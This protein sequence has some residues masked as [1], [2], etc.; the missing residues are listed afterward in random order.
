ML[1]HVGDRTYRDGVDLQA[2]DFYEM[3]RQHVGRTSTSAPTPGDFL[4]AFEEAAKVATSILC[5]TVSK[6]FQLKPGVC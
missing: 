6:E 4:I 1:I 2:S 3:Q 5:I